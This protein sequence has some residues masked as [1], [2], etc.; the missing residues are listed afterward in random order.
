M[1]LGWRYRAAKPA[2]NGMEE[3]SMDGATSPTQPLT[4]IVEAFEKL[5]KILD[6]RQEE[7]DLNLD[8]FCK[9]CSL[10]SILFS[11]LG[12]AF[13]FA[14]ME[15]VSKVFYNFQTLNRSIISS[16]FFL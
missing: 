15:Y 9:A 1:G 16:C 8:T 7:G 3:V 13:K 10:V 4:S 14:E 12:L 5:A 11:C 6:S 2:I